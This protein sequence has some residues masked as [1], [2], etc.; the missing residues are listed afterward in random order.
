MEVADIVNYENLV[1]IIYDNED[2]IEK[3]YQTKKDQILLQKKLLI[4]IVD[5]LKKPEYRTLDKLEVIK[6]LLRDTL[7]LKNSDLIIIKKEYIFIKL[8]DDRKR[9]KISESEINTKANRYNGINEKELESFY[10]ESFSKQEIEDFFY[11][12]AILFVEKYFLYSTI[13]NLEYEKNVTRLL[14]KLI[15]ENIYNEFKYDKEFCLGFSGFIFRKHFKLTFEF[16]AELLLK[17]LASS[18]KSIIK[19][20]KYYSLNVI[21][22]DGKKYKVPELTADN[23]LRWHVGTMMNFTKIYIDTYKHINNFED[24]IKQLN[25]EIASYNIDDLTPI[26]HNEIIQKKYLILYQEIQMNAQKIDILHDSL[27]IITD[28]NELIILNIKLEELKK[29]RMKLREKKAILQGQKVK[30]IIINKFQELTKQLAILKREVKPHYK[31]LK[32][33]EA[34]FESIKRALT[35]ALISKKQLV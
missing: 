23:E 35:K 20:L 10:K 2:S 19:F 31:I 7:E 32:Q 18:N 11:D 13:T 21:V 1:D 8:Y 14:Q 3:N 9:R 17:E 6:L 16:I 12:I 29:Q 27:N 15:I 5:F 24:K 26:E 4:N 33:N 30:Q 34:S 22:I 25:H 28:D